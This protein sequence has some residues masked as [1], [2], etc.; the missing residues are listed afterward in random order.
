M[1]ELTGNFRT[2]YRSAVTKARREKIRCVRLEPDLYYVARR[3]AG[4][5]QYLVRFN[6]KGNEVWAECH[7]LGQVPC[8][9]CWQER[10]CVHI[11]TAVERGIK[12][13]QKQQETKEAA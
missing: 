12:H 2:R 9:G 8:K 1:I 13:G 7:T 10:C 5:G 6:A 3:E 4:H 11:A